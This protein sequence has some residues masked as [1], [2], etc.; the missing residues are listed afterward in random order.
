MLYS[1]S[2]HLR[3]RVSCSRLPVAV[4]FISIFGRCWNNWLYL[5]SICVLYRDGGNCSSIIGGNRKYDVPRSWILFI[6]FIGLL[7][8]KLASSHNGRVL[9]RFPTSA[10]WLGG[11]FEFLMCGSWQARIIDL[12]CKPTYNVS[13]IVQNVFQP[14]TKPSRPLLAYFVTSVT[15]RV[16]L[17]IH[18]YNGC[19]FPLGLVSSIF[20]RCAPR[21]LFKLGQ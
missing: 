13:R 15:S 9:T 10:R 17:L 4:L 16:K 1:V 7:D 12:S 2:G 11:K 20:H 8:S 21:A 3:C 6:V 5:G 14:S 18:F 19:L